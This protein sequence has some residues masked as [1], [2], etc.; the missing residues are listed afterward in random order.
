MAALV[1]ATFFK[2][3][4][5]GGPILL[6]HVLS[7]RLHE[8]AA[9]AVFEGVVHLVAFLLLPLG[10][11]CAVQSWLYARCTWPQEQKSEAIEFLLGAAGFVLMVLGTV[12]TSLGI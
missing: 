10:V 2:I 11:A 9:F 6:S 5:R 8:R 7:Q 4:L 12:V 1:A 3:W